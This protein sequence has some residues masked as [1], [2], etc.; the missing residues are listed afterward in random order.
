VTTSQ[1]FQ[2]G[3]PTSHLCL[4]FREQGKG[5]GR[6]PNLKRKSDSFRH[7]CRIHTSYQHIFEG[8]LGGKLEGSVGPRGAVDKEVV[9]DK[10]VPWLVHLLA[11]LHEQTIRKK[12]SPLLHNG[13]CVGVGTSEGTSNLD[14]TGEVLLLTNRL[15]H[16]VG[17]RR[18]LIDCCREVRRVR[19]TLWRHSH[20]FL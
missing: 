3:N 14:D 2:E 19:M 8:K 16:R 9:E 1:G 20:Q 11:N 4:C 17:K 6:T 10:D 12:S 7:L 18:N 5:L 15:V 13:V